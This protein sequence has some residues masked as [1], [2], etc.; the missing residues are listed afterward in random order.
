MQSSAATYASSSPLGHSFRK[1]FLILCAVVGV[2]PIIDVIWMRVAHYSVEAAS[3]IGVSKA[4]AIVVGLIVALTWMQRI[5]RYKQVTTRLR[6]A[7][8]TDTFACLTLLLIFV[9]S[10]SILSY[11]C[12]TLNPPLIDEDLIRLDRML[13][14]DWLAAYQWV[15]AHEQIRKVLEFAYTSVSIQ[16]LAIPLILGVLRRR[17]NLLDFL[18]ILIL[19]SIF[20]LLISTPLPAASEFIH[21]HITDPNTVSS[22]SHY[23]V[24]RDGTMRT[25][26]L[27][28][29]QGLVSMPSFHTTLAVL[30]AYSVRGVRWLRWPALLLNIVMI[31]SCP[32]QGGHYLVDVITGFLQGVVAIAFVRWANGQKPVNL[33]SD[34]S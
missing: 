18:S 11:L 30:F 2:I 32:T 7:E 1:R 26:D 24:L 15:K 23:A 27:R 3:L 14:F 12:I 13:G 6:Y 29:M 8:V 16:F 20:H 5:P 19:S 33:F 31:V 4:T 34:I 25:F 10:T 17:N 21:F 22:V 9:T 28:A